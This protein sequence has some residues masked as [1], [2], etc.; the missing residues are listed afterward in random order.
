MLVSSWWDFWPRGLGGD[1]AGFNLPEI[2]LSTAFSYLGVA[3]VGAALLRA[4]SPRAMRALAL[5]MLVA[6]PLA[7]LAFQLYLPVAVPVRYGASVIGVS[8]V[9]LAGVTSSRLAGALILAGSAA[10]FVASFFMHW[11]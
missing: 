2:F 3:A 4:E 10:G 8:L 11:P 1:S 9:V 7:A 6:A 5:G